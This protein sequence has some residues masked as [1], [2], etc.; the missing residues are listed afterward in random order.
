MFL[1]TKKISIFASIFALSLILTAC[2]NSK[3]EDKANETDHTEH[4]ETNSTNTPESSSNNAGEVSNQSGDES[5]AV[6]PPHGQPGHRCDIAVGAPLDAPANT[7]SV[8]V[9]NN[10]TSPVI[11]SSSSSNTGSDVKV[12]PPHGQPG[13]RCDIQVGA[14]LE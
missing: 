7:Q 8:N 9:Q 5:V 14:P 12:N 4:V 6:N 2:E 13:H 1:K 11:K 3:K 10:T